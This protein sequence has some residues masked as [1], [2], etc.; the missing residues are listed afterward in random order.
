M[1]E[2]AK[3][4]MQV[5]NVSERTR[6]VPERSRSVVDGPN[7]PGR[8]HDSRSCLV[9]SGGCWTE[10]LKQATLKKRCRYLAEGLIRT[11][12]NA[13]KINRYLKLPA[14]VE[15]NVQERTALVVIACFF[16][17]GCTERTGT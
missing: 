7:S 8:R 15:W 10:E 4:E 5:W 2:L 14:T 3:F 1:P 17:K 9:L 16:R 11:Y 6:N 13:S 12:R